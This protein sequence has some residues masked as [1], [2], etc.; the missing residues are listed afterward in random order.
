M[1]NSDKT[2]QF[3]LTQE[4]Q[5]AIEHLLQGKSDRATAEAAGVARQ[6]I[7]AWRNTDPLFVATLNQRRQEVWAEA[8]ERLKNLT[9]KALDVLENDLSCGD[10]KI[11]LAAAQFLLK[12]MDGANAPI[13]PTTP[14]DV[15]Y[16]WEK[17]K[18]AAEVEKSH[19]GEPSFMRFP[20]EI[21]SEIESKALERTKKALK[22]L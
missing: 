20:E 16:G 5:N 6:T 19:L 9:G 3:E 15:I 4:Q 8:K 12:R 17:A 18:V 22:E 2:R 14:E 10:P 11:E 7:W 21:S 1:T 13:G